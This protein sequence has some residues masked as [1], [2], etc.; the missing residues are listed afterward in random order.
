MRRLLMACLFT[1]CAGRGGTP[2]PDPRFSG[3]LEPIADHPAT[4][5]IVITSKAAPPPWLEPYDNTASPLDNP[6]LAAVGHRAALG[7]VGRQVLMMH[8]EHGISGPL[9]PVE[10]RRWIGLAGDDDRV[11]AA[12][13]DGLLARLDG[14][15]WT[16]LARIP[17]A[18]EWDAAGTTV[19]ACA[20]EQVHVSRDAGAS[21]RAGTPR[22]GLE[23]DFVLA[24][25][26]G[27]VLA[28]AQATTFLSGDG[29]KTW[30]PSAFQPQ[31]DD[32]HPVL[33]RHGAAIWNADYA[34][35]ATL[36]ADGKTWARVMPD[37]NLSSWT[38]AM[39]GS[40]LPEGFPPVRRLTVTTP[41]APA[42]PKGA[43]AS[44]TGTDPCPKHAGGDGAEGEAGEVMAGIMGS[45]ACRGPAVSPW[46]SSTSPTFTWPP[47]RLR[48]L[49]EFAGS[50]AFRAMAMA[51]AARYSTSAR[52]AA[53]CARKTSPIFTWLMR[54]S[55]HQPW[56]PT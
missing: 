21:F 47:A 3:P 32:T 40:D 7:F 34:C 15:T 30:K 4:G 42:A 51:N 55:R 48:W 45:R 12:D 53:P 5:P 46:A 14:T 29:G 54:R 20:G 28:F 26:D 9:P 19:A 33:E 52:G 13:D 16:P 23:I 6:T 49:S 1:A 39:Q 43:D 56:F 8:E 25:H 18:A 2:A 36:S 31:F 38:A 50:L 11:L 41:A 17:G 27:V 24:R 44:V 22:K 10:E 35:P 37:T